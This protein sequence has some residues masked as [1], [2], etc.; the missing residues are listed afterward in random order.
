MCEIEERVAGLLNSPLGCAFLLIA[1]AS[2]LTP[3]EIA[4]PDNAIALA[5][6]AA[7]EIGVWRA[8]RE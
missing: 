8:N 1:G 4:Q 5:A 3:K 6:V 7:N 2:S